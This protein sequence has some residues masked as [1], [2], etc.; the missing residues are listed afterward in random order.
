LTQNDHYDV[1]VAGGGPAGSS[2]A[3]M[4]A[5]AGHDVLLLDREKFPRFRIGESLMPATYWT[6]DRMDVLE[7][8]KCS[9]FPQK[10]SVQF[11][12][13]SGQGSIP[14]YFD[15]T[16][17]GPSAQTWQV[18]RAEFDHMLLRNAAAKGVE[19]HEETRVRDILF[20]GDRA[21]GVEATFPDGE[22]RSITARVV[23][24]ASGQAA[25]IGR[26]LNLREG[27]PNLR[28]CAFYTRYRGAW[29]GEGRDEGATLILYT[30]APRVWFWYI[31]MPDDVVSVGV[32]GP[33]D[34][35]VKGRTND[36]ARIFAE[37][38]AECPALLERI[39]DAEQLH[40]VQA[41]KDFTYANRRMAGDGWITV[42][43][44]FGFLDPIYSSGVFLALKG[45]EFAADTVDAAL[46][47]DDVSGAM[48]NRHAA[49]FSQG[50]EAM[51]LL[52]YAYYSP[53]FNFA[54]FLQEYPEAKDELVNLLI[55][56]VYRKSTAVLIESMRKFCE[57]PGY[58]PF[59]LEEAS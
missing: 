15:E 4:L 9:D 48:L 17:P 39:A 40:D 31:P 32:V 18:D 42:G 19:V 35:L 54:E 51:R 34:H 37:E 10:H 3:T 25:L 38:A 7:Q 26:K 22:T 30:G 1:I 46:R 20:E 28:N 58:E 57:L 44:A 53:K 50:M 43:D 29:R 2:T 56:N 16:E 24:D 13:R 47:A 55:G 33:V 52:V 5:Q 21:V 11:F 14:F 8:M 12:S 23:V 59:P 49:E 6:L 41:I 45:G 36:G 27:D